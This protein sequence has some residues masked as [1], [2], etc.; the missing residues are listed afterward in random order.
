MYFYDSNY[1]L[2]R[3]PILNKI[4]HPLNSH[5][6]YKTADGRCLKRF[7]VF[8]WQEPDLDFEQRIQDLQLRHFFQ[9]QEYLF[10]KSGNYRA[11]LM[12]FY[13]RSS[14]EILTR[15]S[16]YL[17]DNFSEIFDSFDKLSDAFIEARDTNLENTIFTDQD[18]IIIDTER[19]CDVPIEERESV[20]TTNY[21]E[22]SWL[23]FTSLITDTKNHPEL[24]DADF[25]SW[26]REQD[27]HT[28][29]SELTQY[30]YPIEYMRNVKQKIK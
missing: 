21:G 26:F 2:V 6:V 27:G 17:T 1:K 25:Y 28:V 30:K 23:L 20:R 13:E 11:F 8:P 4:S 5:R 18:I 10:N 24:Q 16:D 15:N 12:P 22:A 7:R 9:I 14:K 29:C 3:V 19:Y